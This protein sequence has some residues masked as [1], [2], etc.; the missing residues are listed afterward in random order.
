MRSL[1]IG[2]CVIVMTVGLIPGPVIEAGGDCED[3]LPSRLD[4]GEQGIVLPGAPNNIRAEPS[5]DAALIGSIPGGEVFD[6]LEGPECGPMYVW[7]RVAYNGLE[8][9]TVEGTGGDY[10]RAEA[11]YFVTPL[12]HGAPFDYGEARSGAVLEEANLT[13]DAN[14]RVSFH[15][16]SLA[17]GS[18]TTAELR[19]SVN[20]YNNNTFVTEV[21]PA[22][23]TLHVAS[24]EAHPSM[25]VTVFPADAYAAYYPGTVAE[26]REALAARTGAVYV[27]YLPMVNAAMMIRGRP[28]Y[29]DA[30]WGVFYR[31]LRHYAQSFDPVDTGFRYTAMGLTADERF[32]ILV[33]GGVSVAIPDAIQSAGGMRPATEASDLAWANYSQAIIHAQSQASAFL[34]TAPE[35]AFSPALDVLDNAVASLAFVPDTMDGYL[36]IP[37]EIIEITPILDPTR[38]PSTPEPAPEPLCPGTMASTIVVGEMAWQRLDA[39][40]V[41]ARA[42]PGGDYAFEV[43][44]A[45]VVRVIG[46]PECATRGDQMMVWWQVE[47]VSGATGWIAEATGDTVLFTRL[48]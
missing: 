6:V 5:A 13:P 45:E 28:A 1:I 14:G 8:G 25:D 33:Q 24:S 7:W 40:T 34:D 26:L 36:A 10:G 43:Q 29:V 47:N 39:D 23:V 16:I 17:P 27:R 9:W 30:P 21:L 35:T 2:L 18:A 46:G 4:V 19:D 3:R 44:P 15:G 11:N 12:I 38:A 48:W 31:D 22:H 41:I 20:P 32:I 37:Q 42:E